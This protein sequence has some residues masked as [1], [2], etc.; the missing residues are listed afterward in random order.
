MCSICQ[1]LYP[2]PGRGITHDL[3]DGGEPQSVDSFNLLNRT[4]VDE[5]LVKT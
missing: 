2:S 4:N 1:T 3:S 5:V